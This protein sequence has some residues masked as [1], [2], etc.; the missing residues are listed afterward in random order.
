MSEDIS[1]LLSLIG[2]LG[3]ASGPVFAFLWWLERTERKACQTE[4]KALID[5]VFAV[6]T[7]TANATT[8]ITEAVNELGE[9]TKESTT[10]LVRLIRSLNKPG[11]K[12]V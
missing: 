7:A 3:V 12:N 8:A 9:T 2:G 6:T 11:G 10:Q 4:A 5:R 1:T